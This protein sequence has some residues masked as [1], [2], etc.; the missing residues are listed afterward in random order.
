M[1]S[2]HCTPVMCWRYGYSTVYNFPDCDE[3]RLSVV[4]GDCLLITRV[5]R[6]WVYARKLPRSEAEESDFIPE[7]DLNVNNVSGTKEWMERGW[8]PVGCL[9]KGWQQALRECDERQLQ[10]KDDDGAKAAKKDASK[11]KVKESAATIAGN[12]NDHKT[13]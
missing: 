12:K 8:V 6:Y 3:R 9:R 5:R 1:T 11:K 7:R 2:T 10:Q 4:K 13:S